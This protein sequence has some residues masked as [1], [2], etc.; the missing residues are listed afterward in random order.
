M[1]CTRLV[2]TLV[3]S[4]WHQSL[5]FLP[6]VFPP[7]QTVYGPVQRFSI[8]RTNAATCQA[9]VRLH[10]VLQSKVCRESTSAM[11]ELVEILVKSTSIIR[12]IHIGIGRACPTH[13]P[14]HCL[15]SLSDSRRLQ[16][17]STS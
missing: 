12:D 5:K 4:G 17:M 8:V 13:E 11:A 15:V 6:C 7:C 1:A 16:S 10:I 3:D 9:P 14:V 2:L